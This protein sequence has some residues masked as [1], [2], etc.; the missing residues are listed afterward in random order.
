[1][2]WEK[3]RVIFRAKDQSRLDLIALIRTK[4]DLEYREIREIV[5]NEGMYGRCCFK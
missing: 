4:Y 3:S 5:E 1:M 2:Y